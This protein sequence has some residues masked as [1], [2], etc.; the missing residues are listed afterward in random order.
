[1][2]NAKAPREIWFPHQSREFQLWSDSSSPPGPWWRSSALSNVWWL[3]FYLRKP[4]ED[5]TVF[6]A[7]AEDTVSFWKANWR[8][9]V[10]GIKGECIRLTT[11]TQACQ[12]KRSPKPLRMGS[13]WCL[14]HPRHNT[15]SHSADVTQEPHTTPCLNSVI[16]FK[17]W[18]THTLFFQGARNGPPFPSTQVIIPPT[19]S[20][21]SESTFLFLQS[22]SWTPRLRFFFFCKA[23]FMHSGI[24]FHLPGF[25]Y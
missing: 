5:T 23:L 7:K 4:Q 25:K 3:K 6:L 12:S 2:L 14:T 19:W 17:G 18:Q 22:S 13:R 21:G 8:R 15:G 20:N 24:E 10:S 9:W 1:M 16:W 11:I